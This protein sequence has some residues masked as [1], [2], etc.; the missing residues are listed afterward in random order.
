MNGYI[1]T[2]VEPPSADFVKADP[3]TLAEIEDIADEIL[4]HN[5]IQSIAPEDLE[6]AFKNWHS[7]L[8]Y[9]GML[10]LTFA[11]YRQV[12]R[13]LYIGAIDAST[14]NKMLF[15]PKYGM[16]RHVTVS[17]NIMGVLSGVGFEIHYFQI[18]QNGVAYVECR[19]AK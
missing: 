11:D 9:N 18:D 7:K 10:K 4:A 1:N 5:V 17:E 16:S 13:L 15:N 3:V 12:G 2:K 14:A 8:C 6:T 19:K